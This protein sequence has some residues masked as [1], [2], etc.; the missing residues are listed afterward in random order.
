MAKCTSK[1]R[2]KTQLT[3]L[4]ALVVV[5]TFILDHVISDDLKESLDSVRGAEDHYRREGETSNLSTQLATIQ[6]QLELE[7]KKLSSFDLKTKDYSPMIAVDVAN[8]SRRRGD[9]DVAMD[10]VSRFLDA[11]PSDEERE[12]RNG[13]KVLR[14]FVVDVDKAADDMKKPSQKH[15]WT[16]DVIVKV[17]VA[18]VY[19]AEIYVVVFGDRVLTRAK[20]IEKSIELELRVCT[21]LARFSYMCG[22]GLGLYAQLAGTG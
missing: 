9:L 19:L 17:T 7:N 13:C 18:K 3:V 1:K 22:V 21:W 6:N 10:N 12:L 2:R 16:Q 11:F 15:D 8:L 5:L 20:E 4:A 14:R